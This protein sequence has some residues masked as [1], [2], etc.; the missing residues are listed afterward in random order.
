M[1]KKLKEYR[2]DKKEKNVLAPE[3]KKKRAII[4]LSCYFAFFLLMLF[5]IVSTNGKNT[6]SVNNAYE[7][8]NDIKNP[9]NKRL[10]NYV[11]DNNYKYEFYISSN[12]ILKGEKEDKKEYGIKTY[13]NNQTEYYINNNNYYLKNNNNFTKVDNLNLYEEYDETLLTNDSIIEI[14][15]YAEIEEKKENK[16]NTVQEFKIPL[17]KVLQLYNEI[18]LTE[19][20]DKNNYISGDFTYNNNYIRINLDMSKFY[21]IVYNNDILIQYDLKYFDKDKVNIDID[22]NGEENE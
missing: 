1:F 21:K 18:N 19:F 7:T 8:L 10:S 16:N 3:E 5:L 20:S 11:Y 17:N 12:L 22:L 2:K 14:L 4:L 9:I 13:N 15:S 6:D